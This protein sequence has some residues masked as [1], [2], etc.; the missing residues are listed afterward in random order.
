MQELNYPI[1]WKEEYSM[2]VIEIDDQHKHFVSIL[3]NLY[4]A[5]KKMELEQ[6]AESIVQ[7]LV[8]YA[9]N[10]FATE[11]KYMQ[12]FNYEGTEE[13]KN[14]HQE[15]LGKVTVFVERFS[16][17]GTNIVP[18]LLSFL[19]DWLVGHLNNYDKKYV[20]CFKEHGLK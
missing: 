2:Q 18:E 19:E 1:A 15:L 20:S 6:R 5:M 4:D 3:N 17:E 7:E 11:E 13:H 12:Q 8:A 16:K 10:H 14:Q 9:V